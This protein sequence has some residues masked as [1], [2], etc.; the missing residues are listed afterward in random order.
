[1][2]TDLRARAWVEV[3]AASLRR[4]LG[5]IREAVG[6]GVGLIPMVKADAY[7]LGVTR[8][9][10]VLEGE[11]PVAY[12]VAAVDEGIELR[13]LGITRPVVV[14]SPTDRGAVDEAVRRGL[15]LAVSDPEALAAL[16]GAAGRV[17]TAAGFHVEID[18][19]MGRAGFDW[20]DASAWGPAVN[21]A[22]GQGLRWEGCFTHFHSADVAASDS[23]R[24][25]WARFRTALDALEPPPGLLVHACNSAG[26]LR[27]PEWAA[28][29]VRPGIF[30]FGGRAGDL[31]DRPLPVASVRAR[32]TR[33]REARAGDTLGYGATHV[34]AP[35]ERWA[36]VGIG[37]GDGLPRSLGNRGQGLVR[38]RRVPIIGRIS[39]DMTVVDISRVPGA[40]AGDV[41]TLI[42]SDGEETITVEEVAEL[43][44]TINYEI[45]TG[46]GR[47]LPRIWTDHGS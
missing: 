7:G 31:P 28:G 34:A 18:T 37:Y 42:G 19:G 41:V 8:A 17:G 25:Q 30:L 14:F 36:T 20:R 32:I 11:D 10:G 21:A 35:G 6:P 12:G 40:E 45:L 13:E 16:A 29:A 46:L 27:C 15:S 23:A 2:S 38:G 3:D 26:A 33:V 24:N 1:M 47:R 9:V 5:R 22:H 44:S 43:A 4:N 39:M